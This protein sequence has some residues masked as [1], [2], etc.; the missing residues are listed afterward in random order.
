MS[1]ERRV[2]NKPAL[3]S[4]A[5][6]RPEEVVLTTCKYMT[7]SVSPAGSFIGCSTPGAGICPGCNEVGAS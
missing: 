4:L 3:V 2:W 7:S 1:S 5:R 6:S